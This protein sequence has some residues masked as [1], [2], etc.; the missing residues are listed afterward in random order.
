MITDTVRMRAGKKILK[1]LEEVQY[2]SFSCEK[3]ECLF[4]DDFWKMVADEENIDQFR[5]LSPKQVI[6]YKCGTCY[7]TANYINH[8]LHQRKKDLHIGTIQNIF[9]EYPIN[10]DET[11]THIAVIY[12]VKGDTRWVQVEHSDGQNRGVRVL[13]RIEDVFV[14]NPT[15]INWM[16][17]PYLRPLMMS[18][19][20]DMCKEC[21]ILERR[22]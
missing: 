19:Y 2:G 16:A 8:R 6:Q 1:E 3:N 21:G 18:E 22:S 12:Q 14:Q 11:Q 17:P 15:F 20:Y 13:N 4:G 5:L 10:V 7:D 9:Y